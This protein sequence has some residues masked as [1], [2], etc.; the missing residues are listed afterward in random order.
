M[1]RNSNVGGRDEKIPS[2]TGLSMK[3]A[4]KGRSTLFNVF[5]NRIEDWKHRELT[6]DI[7]D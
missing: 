7:S 5:Q 3:T 1:Y 2:A 6:A 4:W